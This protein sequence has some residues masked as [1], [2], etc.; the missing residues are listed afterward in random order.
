GMVYAVIGP[1]EVGGFLVFSWMGF[2]GLFLFYRAFRMALPNAD[3]R[4]YALLLFFLPSLVFWPSSIGKE[5]WVTLTLGLTAYG[6][7]RL[8]ARRPG[9]FLVFGL[10]MAGLT[11]VRPHTALIAFAAL[12]VGYLLRRGPRSP[13]ALM[14][15]GFGAALLIGSSL[16]VVTQ[17]KEFLGVDRLDAATIDQVLSA[18][19]RNTAQGGSEFEAPRAASPAQAPLALASI[20]FRPFLFEVRSPLPFLAAAEGTFLAGLCLTS[21]RRLARLP[22]HL[23]RSPYVAAS[24]IYS[25]IFAFAFSSFGNFGIIVRQRVQLLPFF[26]VLLALPSTPPRGRPAQPARATLVSTGATR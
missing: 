23:R 7:A 9:A 11:T 1:T 3:A 8:I 25:L 17:V 10:G 15:K 14:A 13:F 19:E 21:R 4:R 18:T 24:L 12:T 26:L 6:G 20:L 5:A 2:L 16:L 22:A